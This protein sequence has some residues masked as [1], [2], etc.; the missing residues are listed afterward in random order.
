MPNR[1][2]RT[3]LKQS[4][5]ILPAFAI[6]SSSFSANDTIRIG[7]IGTGGRCRHLLRD[8]VH[9]D[10]VKVT[11]LCDVWEHHLHMTHNALGDNLYTTKNYKDI[12]E[13]D[14]IDAVLIATPNHWHVPMTVEACQAGKD[15]YV[16]KPLTVKLNEGQEAIDAQKKYK[17]IVQVGQQQRSMT[18][19]KKAKALYQQGLT[20]P[21]HKVHL[22]WNRNSPTHKQPNYN[23]DP[24][25][26]DWNM[27]LGPVPY[28]PFDPYRFRAWRWTW[29]FGGGILTDLMVHYLDVAHWFFDL[30]HPDTANTIG[31]HVTT[32][33]IWETPDTIQTLLHYKNKKLQVYFEGTFVNARNAAMMEFMGMDA[34][35]Y[36]DRGRYELH[37]ENTRKG[38]KLDYQELILGEGQR[39]ADFYNKPN[40]GKLHLQNWIDCMRSRQ[41]PIAPAEAGVSASAAAHLANLAYR[42]HM[43]AQWEEEYKGV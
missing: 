13:R 42:K 1:D 12:L 6:A 43:V 26:V 33:G 4:G 7:C 41:K 38:K 31:D 36:M 40:G 14:D 27:F 28:Q 23:I 37:P 24:Q 8:L 29:D 35:L 32:Q 30:E 15:V 25:T 19:I 18:H 10:G 16:E 22:T 3:F 21:V 17:R 34:T 11:A 2:R 39:G 9:L 5:S 20:G